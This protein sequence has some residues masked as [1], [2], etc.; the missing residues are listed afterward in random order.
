[1]HGVLLGIV[2]MFFVLWF[3]K[4]YKNEKFYIGHKISLIDER[5]SK[6]QP[7]DF[8][9]RL[10]RSLVKD[11]KYWKGT[12]L[13]SFFDSKTNMLISYF[14]KIQFFKVQFCLTL[15]FRT[16]NKFYC[17]IAGISLD[18]MHALLCCF[19]VTWH[20]TTLNCIPRRQ[21]FDPL[22]PNCPCMG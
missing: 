5:L 2:K 8:I 12:I 6:C 16:D 20:W 9:S 11:R 4:K 18:L 13:L 14:H 1:M 22:L 17:Y 19:L 21:Q 10:P 7:P 15:L 3:D